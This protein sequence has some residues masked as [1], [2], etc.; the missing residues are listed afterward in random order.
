M[1]VLSDVVQNALGW[2][3]SPLASRRSARRALGIV[4]IVAVVSPAAFDGGFR[5]YVQSEACAN[6]A[7]PVRL[8]FDSLFTAP[9]IAQDLPQGEHYV[10]VRT[11]GW[12][13]L[14]A[15]AG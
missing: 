9:A 8:Y 11:N 12:C 5:Q 13:S 4:A 10:V 1:S 14:K 3:G 7:G 15:V 2:S 6:I